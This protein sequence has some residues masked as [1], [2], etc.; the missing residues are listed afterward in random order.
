MANRCNT[1]LVEPA[2]AITTRMAFS[3]ALRVMMS[4]G[5]RSSLSSSM[6]CCPARKLSEA[7]SPPTAS[8]ELEPGRLMPSASMAEAMVLAVYMPPQEPG[9][10]IA[11]SSICLTWISLM[12]PRAFWPT[13]SNTE[14]MSVCPAPGRMVPP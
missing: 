5:L 9:P 3:K 2:R 7:L 10:G 1:A 13:A 12:S 6:T 11:T 8:W 4:R 14:M